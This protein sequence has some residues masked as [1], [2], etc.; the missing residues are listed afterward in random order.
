LVPAAGFLLVI[1]ASQSF[2]LQLIYQQVRG[3][4]QESLEFHRQNIVLNLLAAQMTQM[5][6][7]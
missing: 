7:P 3:L 5:L 6:K 2:H 1:V 4:F